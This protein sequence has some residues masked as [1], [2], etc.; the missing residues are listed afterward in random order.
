MS[1]LLVL[2]LP[3]LTGI[4][5]GIFGRSGLYLQDHVVDDGVLP[6]SLAAEPD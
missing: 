6:A 5:L 2:P 1:S 3:H 4:P